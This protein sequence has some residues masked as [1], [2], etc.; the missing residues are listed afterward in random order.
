MP[1]GRRYSTDRMMDAL[2]REDITTWFDLGLMLDRLRDGHDTPSLVVDEDFDGFTEHVSN[3]VGI[4]TFHCSVD[5]VTVEIGKYVEALRRVLPKPRIHVIAG[6]FDVRAES[7]LGSHIERHELPQLDGFSAWPLYRDFFHRRMERGSPLYNDLIRALW[8]DV[9]DLVERLGRL[10][11]RCD[12]RL[13]YL[14]NVNS[15]PGNVAL[16][17]ALVLISEHLRL[18]VIANNHDFYWE[19]GGS[20][21]AREKDGSRAGPRDHFFMNSHLGEVFSVIQMIYPWIARTWIAANISRAQSSQL[22]RW[23]GHNPANVTEL[24]TAVD[25][26]RYA[27]LNRPRRVEVLRQ[28]S[29]LLTGKRKRLG[30]DSV[31]E[32]LRR[33][34]QLADS[35]EPM[36]L[37]ARV[38]R[39]VDFVRDNMILLQPTRIIKRKKIE[40]TFRL[41][42]RLFAD[43]EF[44]DAFRKTPNL[45]LTLLVTGPVAAENDRYFLRLLRGFDTFV[46]RLAEPVRDRVFFALLH[47]GIDYPDFRRR[48]DYPCTIADV[49]GIASL[50]VLPSETE[51]RGLPIIESAACGVPIMTRRYDPENVFAEVIGEHLALDERLKV[52]SFRSRVTPALVASV[53]EHLLYPLHFRETSAH[54]REVVEERYAMES[55]ASDFE[56]CFRQLHRQLQTNDGDLN[57]AAKALSQFESRVRRHDG[58]LGKVV[59][60]DNREYLPGHGRMRFMLMLKSLIDP[61]YFRVEE[62]RQRGL[63][64]GFAQRLVYENPDPSTLTREQFH[65]FCNCVDNLF[66]VRDGELAVMFDHAFAYRHRHRW[67]LKYRAL[68]WH[69]LTGVI[70]LLFAKIAAPP[71]SFG[72]TRHAASHFSNWDLMLEQ[73]CGGSLAIDDRARLWEKLQANVPIAYF[74]GNALQVEIELFIL[75]SIR[76]RLGLEPREAMTGR[77]LKRHRL[78]PIHFFQRSQPLGN[79]RTA[80]T[81]KA[82]VN[83]S[84]NEELQLLFKTGVCNVVP[85]NQVSVGID[86]RQLGKRALQVLD[87]VRTGGGFLIGAIEHAS[88]TTDIL[89]LERFHVGQVTDVLT[90]NV[91]GLEQGDGYVQW[92]PA[93]LRATLAYPTP[94]QTARDLSKTFKGS[95]FRRACRKLGE[96]AVLEELRL[97]A[98]AHGSTVVSVLR[99]LVKPTSPGE[100]AVTAQAING[101]YEDGFPWSGILAT[102]PPGAGMRYRIVWADGPPRTVLEFVRR[103]NRRAKAKACIGWNGGYILNPELVG[104]LG[105]P[106]SYIGSPLGLIISDGEAVCPP[107]FNKPALLIGKDDSLS[108]R[109]VNVRSGFRISGAGVSVDF[110]PGAYNSVV[111]GTGPCFYD[112]SFADR[113]IPGDGRTLVRLAGVRVMEVIR[114][115]PGQKVPVLPVGLCLSFPRGKLPKGWVDGTRLDFELPDLVDV[116]QA[117]EA[118][119]ML[120]SGARNCIDMDVEG[121]KTGNSIAT[122]A[123]RLDYL[124]MRGPKI[125]VGIDGD[126]MLSVLTVNGRIRESV[127]ATHVEMAEILAARGAESAMGFDPGGSSTLVVGDE[128]L[129]ISPYNRDYEQ[130]V[131]SMPPQPRAVAN[132]VIGF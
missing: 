60:T 103:F 18:P 78:A 70:N 62:Q 5:G 93:S 36:L 58:E 55:L 20:R 132:A 52:M 108:I 87:D 31:A 101:I 25:T 84:R 75:Q 86:V 117:V 6:R 91:M 123:A 81:L 54:N 109:R 26:V 77:L 42:A 30:A 125:A 68:T 126:G 38:V 50:V 3:G 19:G 130:N 100:S 63:A 64:F 69:E 85:T 47:S 61:S 32:I 83:Q 1:Q 41:I 124:D 89:D 45:K 98:Q 111:P 128:T 72:A 114:T 88:L 120:L 66:L 13:L 105:L 28:L 99:K 51:G 33:K 27:P 74:A 8:D 95:L 35:P 113:T 80:D 39:S 40:T 106:E 119:P 92:V 129:N 104:K 102:V 7:I 116:A 11:E 73:R 90:A 118:G 24:G 76:A 14:V 131:Y 12:I 107:L 94:I 48:F 82:Y 34:P 96:R 44:I 110:E 53:K 121:W 10:F 67:N 9:L 127:G 37:A 57:T 23:F 59:N 115:A 97:D 15:N 122:Q 112:L 17:L 79:E 29:I 22:V 49:Y 16:A 21:A 43:A 46:S 2:R 56:E 71:P 65:E 4:V